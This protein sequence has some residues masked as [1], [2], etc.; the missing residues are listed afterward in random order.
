[1]RRCFRNEN[2]GVVM[3]F[4]LGAYMV[5]SPGCGSYA[6]DGFLGLGTCD[7]LNCDGLF[8]GNLAED[9]DE[10]DN[11]VAGDDHAD[12]VAD[13]GDVAGADE[14]DEDGN[15]V[16]EEHDEAAE[17]DDGGAPAQS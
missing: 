7:V 8:F 12:D 1:M 9:H 13:T 6:T 14:H 3:T 16:D 11:A 17:G 5:L 2:T 15:A 4:V 10:A